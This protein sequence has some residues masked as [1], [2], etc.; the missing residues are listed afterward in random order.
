M[1]IQKDITLNII[2]RVNNDHWSN[3]C[4]N[5]FCFYRRNNFDRR[6][7]DFKVAKS[8]INKEGRCRL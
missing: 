6:E 8:V 4:S 3:Q 1:H 5:L 7:R 2:L